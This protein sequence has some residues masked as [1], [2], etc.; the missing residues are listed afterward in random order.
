MLQCWNEDLKD[1][2]SFH[3]ILTEVQELYN[4]HVE[5]WER[6]SADNNAQI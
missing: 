3:D 6:T 1:R 4:F 2:P 5:K